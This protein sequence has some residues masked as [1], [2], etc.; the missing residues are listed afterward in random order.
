MTAPIIHLYEVQSR[1]VSRVV[2]Y[3]TC[4]WES[5]PKR[6]PEQAAKSGHLHVEAKRR[7]AALAALRSGKGTGA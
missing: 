1:G 6:T 3:C 5:K 2:A 4:Q 7:A